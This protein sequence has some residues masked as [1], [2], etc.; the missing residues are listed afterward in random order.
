MTAD[1]G[2][3]RL[4]ALETLLARARRRPL[5][6]S[7]W[8]WLAQLAGGDTGRWPVGPVSALGEMGELP[9]LP[10]PRDCCLRVEPLGMDAGQQGAFRLPARVLDIS[11]SEAEALAAAFAEAFGEDGLRLQVARP[12]RWYLA[13]P[14]GVEPWRGFD[15]PAGALAEHA[16]PV[17][18][19]PALSR[20]LS[21]AE[22][23]F[24][25]HP[26]NE[27]RRD[28]GLPLIAGMHPWGGGCLQH[29]E[30]R[31]R[32]RNGRGRGGGAGSD[33]GEPFLAGLRRLGVLPGW[34][35]SGERV[36]AG[37][38]S[39]PVADEASLSARLAGIE[40]ELA[41]PLLRRLRR[42]GLKGV[43]IVTARAVHETRPGDLLKLWRRRAPLGRVQEELRAAAVTDT[44][45]ASC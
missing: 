26:V 25:A 21:E 35:G 27:A 19:E 37:G 24:H 8:D 15:G 4:P 42:G 41:V 20:L 22:M 40:Q 28:R 43:R 3:P 33:P 30:P 12:D 45:W 17:P 16:R 10:A 36:Q 34:G 23:L 13:Q 5:Q 32:P 38:I 18:A 14:A 7:A 39:W 9:A 31:D 11:R 44:G 1:A 2:S 29:D 6:G